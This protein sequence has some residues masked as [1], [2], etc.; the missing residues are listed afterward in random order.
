MRISLLWAT[1]DGSSVW[2][3]LH[4]IPVLE[5]INLDW[6]RA[7]HDIVLTQ[8]RLNRINISETN[9]CRHCNATDNLSQRFIEC[10]E[11]QVMWEWKREILVTILWTNMR[12]IPDGWLLSPTI[13]IWPRT[14][15][16]EQCYGF[17]LTLWRTV[18]SSGTRWSVTTS[19]TFWGERNGSYNKR[20]GG[21]KEWETTCVFS[22]R[23]HH[24]G[25]HTPDHVRCAICYGAS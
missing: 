7:I 17:S 22:Q 23:Y 1:T 9:L 6:Y 12:H 16:G 24:Q 2:S 21:T 4:G 11:C 15:E 25:L 19:V 14:N 3:N 13:S 8:D 5:D 20:H 10:G 18:C